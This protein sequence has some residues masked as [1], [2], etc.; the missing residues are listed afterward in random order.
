MYYY[1]AHH[2]NNQELSASAPEFIPNFKPTPPSISGDWNYQAHH[3]DSSQIYQPPPSSHIYPP[4]NHSR[5]FQQ[6]QP[7]QYQQSR[8]F[9]QA[10]QQQSNRNYR[11]D[12]IHPNYSNH[13]SHQ[14]QQQQHYMM[15]LNYQQGQGIGGGG[16]GGGSAQGDGMRGGS[17]LQNRLNFQNSHQAEPVVPHEPVPHKQVNLILLSF[18][19]IILL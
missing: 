3:Q 15:P 14:Q 18:F 5:P 13:L 7:Q 17:G 6:Q 19:T 8:N 11:P 4:Q 10:Y 9:Q 16:G 2:R 1:A 12:L